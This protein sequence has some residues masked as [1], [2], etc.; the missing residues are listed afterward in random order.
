MKFAPVR[1]DPSQSAIR[2]IMARLPALPGAPKASPSMSTQPA[3]PRSSEPLTLLLAAPHR[4]MFFVGAVALLGNMVWWTWTLFAAWRGLPLASYALPPAIAHG[5]LMQ[6]ATLAPFVLGFLLTVF[7]RWL[8]RPAVPRANYAVVF[9]LILGGGALVLAAQNGAPAAL[10]FGLGAVLLGWLVAMS[11]LGQRLHES[12][13][14]DVWAISTFVAL[15]LGALGLGLAL[16]YALGA[17]PT[18]LPAAIAIGTFGLLLPVYFT[19][20]HRMV[21]F[22][23]SNVISG[24]RVVRPTWS[25]LCVWALSLAHLAA[26][27]C[28][29]MQWRWLADLPLAAVLLWQWLAWQPWKARKPGLLTVLYIALAWLPISFGLFAAESLTALLTGSSGWA[30]APLHAL[31]IGFF[32]SMLVAMVTRVTHGHSG[33]PLAMGVVP[34]LAFVG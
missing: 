30:R 32:S 16:S 7:P 6:Y 34:W 18:L 1:S 15:A 11:V 33:R 29:A 10:A 28:G 5:L 22:F 4:A 14:R 19:V 2:P 3:S 25:L 12:G 31:T 9:G 17:S 26:D 27:L 21:P 8:D 20:A 23:S 24:Y 13:Y